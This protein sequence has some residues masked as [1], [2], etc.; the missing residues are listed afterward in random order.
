MLPVLLVLVLAGAVIPGASGRHP[1]GAVADF[2]PTGA[3]LDGV[4]VGTQD[5]WQARQH[6]V[7]AIRAATDLTYPVLDALGYGDDLAAPELAGQWLVVDLQ[8][9]GAPGQLQ[10]ISFDVQPDRITLQAI[11]TSGTWTTFSRACRC[12]M[13]LR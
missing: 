6:L 2:L 5:V 8:P 4:A 11:E 9:P 12:S 7:P 10:T 1:D 13:P 3:R